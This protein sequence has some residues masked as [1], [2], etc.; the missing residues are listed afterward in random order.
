MVGDV[1]ERDA[2]TL[3][4]EQL[5]GGVEDSHSVALC[6]LAQGTVS[7]LGWGHGGKISRSG[8]TVSTSVVGFQK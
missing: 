8:L 4:G 3:L 5:T 1:V 2:E 6:V 7:G